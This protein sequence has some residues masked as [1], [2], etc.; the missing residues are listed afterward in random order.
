MSL[1]NYETPA[2]GTT[3]ITSA[4]RVHSTKENEMK[5]K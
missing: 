1:E 4:V 2:H 5:F 3:K